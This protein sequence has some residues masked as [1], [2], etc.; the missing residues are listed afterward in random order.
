MGVTKHPCVHQR[1]FVFILTHGDS[2]L[3]ISFSPRSKR[4]QSVMWR[5][6]GELVHGSGNTQAKEALHITAPHKAEK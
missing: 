1:D 4:L 5:R 6:P 3:Q 2:I